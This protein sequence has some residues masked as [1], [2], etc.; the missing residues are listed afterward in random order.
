MTELTRKCRGDPLERGQWWFNQDAQVS[1]SCPG[2]G[3]IAN[4]SEHHIGAHGEV[5][6]SVICE[7]G[8]HDKVML[9]DYAD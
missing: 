2:C 4:L 8:F 3:G 5:E 7:C 1:V 9:H 6:P